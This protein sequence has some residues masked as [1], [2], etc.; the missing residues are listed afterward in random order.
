MTKRNLMVSDM[1]GSVVIVSDTLHYK[2][3]DYVEVARIEKKTGEIK[4]TLKRGLDVVNENVDGHKNGEGTV[5]EV[6]E[7]FSE[8]KRNG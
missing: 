7:R 1:G 4:W 5:R 3:G 2:N 8:I 6:V